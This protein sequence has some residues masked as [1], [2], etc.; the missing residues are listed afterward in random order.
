MILPL[1]INE[2]MPLAQ[3]KSAQRSNN[4]ARGTYW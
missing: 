4:N 1:D 2:E 3:W